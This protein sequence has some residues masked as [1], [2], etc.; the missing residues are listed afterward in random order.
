MSGTR[1]EP[2]VRGAAHGRLQRVVATALVALVAIGLLRLLW[3][4][5]AATQ[6]GSPW[7]IGSAVFALLVAY[8]FLMASTTTLDADGIRQSGLLER[9]VA[10]SEIA[11]VR[12]G[13]FG[14]ARLLRVRTRGGRRIAFAGATPELEAAFARVVAE[15][16]P[17]LTVDR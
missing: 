16:S 1:F 4:E 7:F 13:G 9:K 5:P 17:Q 6:G 11:S 3:T 10:W 15:Q 12:L 14:F 8:A 2:P